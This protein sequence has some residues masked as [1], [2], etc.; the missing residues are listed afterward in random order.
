[1]KT[2]ELIISSVNFIGKQIDNI[3]EN[4]YNKLDKLKCLLDKLRFEQIELNKW[5]KESIK[6]VKKA[7]K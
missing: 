3:D 5:Y 6:N 1:M 2:Y 4:D 7:Q